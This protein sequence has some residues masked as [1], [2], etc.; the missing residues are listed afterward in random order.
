MLGIFPLRKRG[1]RTLVWQTNLGKEANFCL[2]IPNGKALTPQGCCASICYTV[3]NSNRSVHI[4]KARHYASSRERVMR[5]RTNWQERAQLQ[6]SADLSLL[7]RC[8]DPLLSRVSRDTLRNL[9]SVITGHGKF[10]KNL[11]R[12]GLS[13]NPLCLACGL[14][15]ETVFHFM[16]E[17]PALSVARTHAFGKPLLNESEY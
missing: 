6:S 8:R 5:W 2:E 10:R 17:C 4:N 13:D 12:M 7:W 3:R 11:H 9:V 15:K 14:E 1:L 16:C